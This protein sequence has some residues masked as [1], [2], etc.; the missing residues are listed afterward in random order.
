MSE[1]ESRASSR[2]IER[3]ADGV[4]IDLYNFT[5]VETGAHG[6]RMSQTDASPHTMPAIADPQG[7]SLYQ[8]AFGAGVSYSIVFVV[9][10]DAVP[11]TIT[12]TGSDEAASKVAY[13]G[14]H[15]TVE[16]VNDLFPAGVTLLGC[17]D[18]DAP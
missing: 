6:T 18:G 13:A 16:T 2:Q 1:R 3:V 5:E 15:Y 9:D 12:G 4:T 8:D 14:E 10:K 17:E 11:D 7:E